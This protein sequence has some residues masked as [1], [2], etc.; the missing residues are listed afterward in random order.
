MNATQIEKTIKQAV[1]N[2]ESQ[3]L[4]LN[5]QGYCFAMAEIMQTRLAELGMGSRL[6]ECQLTIIQKSPPALKLIGHSLKSQA[7][8]EQFD[9]HMVCVTETQ[10]A[11]LIDLSLGTNITLPAE[12]KDSGIMVDS[13]D[14]VGNTRL[15]YRQKETPSFPPILN[16]NIVSRIK[17][18]LEMRA[19]VHWL[20]VLVITLLVVS[21]INAGR[22]IFEAYQVWVTP[23]N[24]WG[25]DT[26]KMLNDK[27]DHIDQQLEPENLKKRLDRAGVKAVPK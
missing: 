18:D 25:P 14:A 10:P 15:I 11:Y 1:D 24:Y 21:T 4:L 27:I 22:G 8:P 19:T 9:T 23:D 3:G 2:I 7:I 6:V 12:V 16:Q 26:L 20:K 13:F 17:S 5:G